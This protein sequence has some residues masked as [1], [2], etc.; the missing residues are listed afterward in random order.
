M[1]PFGYTELR[2]A[3]FRI[4]NIPPYRADLSGRIHASTV[5]ADT[6]SRLP[7]SPRQATGTA[8]SRLATPRTSCSISTNSVPLLET[9][10]APSGGPSGAGVLACRRTP[11]S[12]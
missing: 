8:C 2:S 9:I 12:R 4:V 11:S 3:F 5:S 1:G 10:L 7:A 6:A